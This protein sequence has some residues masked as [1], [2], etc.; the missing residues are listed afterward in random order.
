MLFAV[1]EWVPLSGV[2]M[3]GVDALTAGA[4]DA[5]ISAAVWIPGYWHRQG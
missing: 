4:A 5:E 2:V 3:E 1:A